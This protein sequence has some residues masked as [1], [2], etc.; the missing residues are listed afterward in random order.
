MSPFQALY[1]YSPPLLHNI[2]MPMDSFQETTEANAE[3]ENMLE[4]LQKN[5]A[6]AQARMK[7][8][9]DS[10]RTERSFELGDMVYL[11][12]K[13]YRE[14]ALGRGTPPKFTPRWYGPFKVLQKIGK[15]SYKL[16]L[17]DGC[18][19]HN[20]FHVSHL[21][22]HTGPTAVPHPTLPLVTE[23][24]KIKTYPF[25][26]LQRRL[27]PRPNGEY[28]IAVAQWLIQWEAMTTDEAT[29]ED[30]SF[31]QQAFPDFQP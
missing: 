16:H 22:K 18:K 8:Y 26:V 28:D 24:G 3:K 23:D 1:E 13:P 9:A 5:L 20:V 29:W 12:A 15:V 21:K 17:P 27:V 25:A 6:R 14:Q 11:K 2:P 7:K 10:Q 31:I 4:L 19:L 30:A